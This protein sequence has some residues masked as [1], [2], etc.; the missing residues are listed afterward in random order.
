MMMTWWPDGQ[1]TST[2]GSFALG[3][4][5]IIR[6]PD[7]R[8]QTAAGLVQL[9]RVIEVGMEVDGDGAS[10]LDPSRIYRGCSAAELRR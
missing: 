1:I 5:G 8:I 10:D 3:P 2:E 6:D 4:R 9:V 7:A